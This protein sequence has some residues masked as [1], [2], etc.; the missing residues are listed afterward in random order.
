MNRNT[1]LLLAMRS[2]ARRFDRIQGEIGAA[3]GLTQIEVSILAFL[4]NNPGRDTA[5]DIIELRGF[6]KGAVSQG[7][8][9]LVRRGLLERTADGGDRRRVRLRPT[10]AASPVCEALGEARGRYFDACF[11]GFSEEELAR[12]FALTD[13]V[14]ANV[15]SRDVPEGDENGTK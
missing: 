5:S 14:V 11:A 6:S 15:L 9:R 4:R 8:D 13:R 10:A 2:V 1:E 7:I 3:F 12:Y